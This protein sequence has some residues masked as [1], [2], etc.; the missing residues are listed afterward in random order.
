MIPLYHRRLK[1]ADLSP[2]N[3]LRYAQ[4]YDEELTT[5]EPLKIEASG[6]KYFRAE[7][8]TSSYVISFDDSEIN[9]QAIFIDRAKELADCG[10]R[11]PKIY[12]FDLINHLTLMEDVGDNSLINEGDFYQKEDLVFS[13]LK[14]LNSM[15]QSKFE[16]LDTTFWIGLESHS[17]KFSEVFCDQFLK[18][19]MFDKYQDLY[20]NLRHGIMDQQWT[21]CHFD[22]ERRNIHLLQ[23]GD[24]AL[25]DFQDMCFG[26][27]GIDLAGILIDHY[28]PCDLDKVKENCKYFSSLS[29]FSMSSDDVYQA[30]LWGGLQRNLR[31]M[32]TLTQLYLK[33]N[34]SFRMRDLPQIVLNTAT[35]STALNQDMLSNFLLNDVMQILERKLVKL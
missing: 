25:I 34:R 14:L 4:T 13:T 1:I 26:P 17:K 31:I 10:V 15:H 28:I 32:G 21:N 8:D 23:N 9:G 16:N 20:L 30:T 11:V 12:H 6:R 3:L 27:I 33:F 2:S 19:K 29:V 35:I 24:L 18:L 7:S 22:F 5:L